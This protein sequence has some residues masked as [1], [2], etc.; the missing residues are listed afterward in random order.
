MYIT[1]CATTIVHWFAP[2][3]T[4][5]YYLFDTFRDILLSA[6]LHIESDKLMFHNAQAKMNPHSGCFNGIFS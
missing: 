6:S 3:K 5:A 1:C 2:A 4:M